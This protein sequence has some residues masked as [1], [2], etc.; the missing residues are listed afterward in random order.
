MFV[1]GSVYYFFFSSFLYFFLT[2]L[3]LSLSLSL[4]CFQDDE[5]EEAIDGRLGRIGHPSMLVASVYLLRG[6]AYE[7]LDNRERAI[8]W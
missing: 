5:T 6:R 3:S 1:C 7:E 4:S 8:E 2:S